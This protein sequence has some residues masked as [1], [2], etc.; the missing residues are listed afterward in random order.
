M[1]YIIGD[2]IMENEK[3][4]EISGDKAIKTLV[5][6]LSETNR[7]DRER[8]FPKQKFPAD[9]TELER[10]IAEMLT[11]DTGAN[12]LD[13]GNIYGRHWERNRLIKDFRKLK[14]LEVDID[15]DGSIEFTLNIFHFLR[16]NLE[17][18]DNK[19]LE[20]L[21]EKVS[22]NDNTWLQNM[23]D[24]AEAL[25]ELGWNVTPTFNTYNGDNILSQGIQGFTFYKDEKD[26]ES[27]YIMLQIHNGSDIRGG[28]TKPRIFKVKDINLFITGQHDITAVCKCT[29]VYTDDCG[30]HWYESDIDYKLPTYWEVVQG[31]R[32]NR[33]VCKKCNKT[34]KFIPDLD[35]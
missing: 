18:N 31:K 20:N 12:I 9:Y 3:D 32:G 33:L 14:S 19:K 15:E 8:K 11:E 7:I 2:T 1:N 26:E 29:Q 34:V 23:E 27:P 30:Y 17:V 4:K 10:Q 6:V 28:Y 25:E 22:D 13:S 16:A 35:E 5:G 24:F 21:F